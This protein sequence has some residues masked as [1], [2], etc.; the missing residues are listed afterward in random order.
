[1]EIKLADV[2]HLQRQQPL[3][4]GQGPTLPP[5][6]TGQD[7]K[8]PRRKIM[9]RT[10]KG[11]AHLVNLLP[12]G[13]VLTYQVLS[14]ISTN[15]GHCASLG[16]YLSVGLLALCAM[17]CFLLSFTDSF[18]DAKGKVRYGIATREGLWV[19]DGKYANA[20]SAEEAAKYRLRFKDFIHAVLSVLVFAAVAL[21]DKNMVG[22]FC[23]TPSE[24]MKNLLS[25][26]P[27]GICVFCTVLFV[28][29]PTRRQGI[30]CPLA[31]S[32]TQ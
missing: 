25:A 2:E 3:L 23:P 8:P 5:A 1:M 18:K 12:T 15:Q 10:F 14:P 4:G 19:F 30:G 22:C 32:S 28:I 7:Q 9:N 27:I 31:S 21:I 6:P 11:T 20:L 17:S 29:L 16:R 24:K 26:V 13:T